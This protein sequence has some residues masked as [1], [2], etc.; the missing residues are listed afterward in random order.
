MIDKV[1]IT[2]KLAGFFKYLNIDNFIKVIIISFLY[3]KVNYIQEF[4]GNESALDM[5]D[6]YIYNLE[7]NLKRITK[8][9][10]YHSIY[11]NYDYQNKNLKYYITSNYKKI[12]KI[13]LDKQE[14][15]QILIQEFKMMMYKELEK[16]INIY[17]LNGRIISNSFYIEDLHGRYP[18]YG[19]DFSDIID[20]FSDVEVCEINKINKRVK[21]F[22]DPE[23]KY[24]VY[25]EHFSQRNSEVTSYVKIWKMSMDKK[26]LY[27]AINNPKKY[28]EKMIE[29]FNKKYDYIFEAN[30]KFF[31]TNK[32]V[33]SLIENYILH[34]RNRID[35]ENNVR[36]HQDLSVIF[37]LMQ[38]KK[39]ISK[40]T[41]YLLHSTGENNKLEYKIM[42]GFIDG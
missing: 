12:E 4:V 34:I 5:L 37:E 33:F 28:S 2:N 40:Y 26:M 25:A 20:V 30:Y 23:K 7:H 1:L 3:D 17:S 31:L 39:R 9:D 38:K 15:K 27:F 11:A 22:I 21:T 29:E 10:S 32:D 8:L 6:K 13:K 19:G 18:E 42:G 14:K 35:E 36:Y 41:S 16:I 24:F